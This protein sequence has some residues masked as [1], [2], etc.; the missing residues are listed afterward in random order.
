VREI[1]IADNSFNPLR[2]EEI[3]IVHLSTG[4][5]LTE[6]GVVGYFHQLGVISRQAR[7]IVQIPGKIVISRTS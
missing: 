3:I 6:K 7:F 1:P 2:L 5:N 4:E